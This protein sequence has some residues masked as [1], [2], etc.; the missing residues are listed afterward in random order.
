VAERCKSVLIKKKQ[1][2]PENMMNTPPAD[3]SST[4][5]HPPGSTRFFIDYFLHPSLSAE[6]SLIF[7]ARILIASQAAMA[8]C[9]VLAVL[10]F[11]FVPMPGL[12][13][14]IGAPV[15]GAFIAIFLR[16]LFKL[17]RDG[18]YQ[19]CSQVTVWTLAIPITAG[20]LIS[21]GV[22]SSPV[23][24]LLM[25]P[26]LLMAFFFSGVRGGIRVAIV[27]CLVVA[28]GFAAE[29]YDVTFPQLF[30]GQQM[31]IALFAL[32]ADGIAVNCIIAFLFEYIS[33]TLRKARDKEHQNIVR[34][35]QTDSLTGIAN[36]R[37]FDDALTERIASYSSGKVQPFALCYLDLNGFK[38]INDRHGHHVGDQVLRAIS[39]RLQSSLRG[40]DLIGRQGG[41]EFMLLL[42]GLTEGP[43]LQILA[44]RFLTIISEPIETSAGLISVG[45]SLGF[46][47]YPYHGIDTKSLKQAA[48]VAMYMA[49]RGHLGWGVHHA[50]PHSG[51]SLLE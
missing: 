29:S 39:I 28:V 16:L 31:D 25:G 36:R 9:S 14:A 23:A 11:V 3:D 40:T 48:D 2:Q 37:A 1:R 44:S 38:P 15:C 30:H 27:V 47:F 32:V 17:R 4:S 12:Y 5:Q 33:D 50:E 21:G 49:K 20:T 6:S 7:R 46:A 13:R 10:F 22:S 35:V 51:L 45:G 24:N 41:D 19:L 18:S 42:E 26:P 8:G 43:Q 34:L